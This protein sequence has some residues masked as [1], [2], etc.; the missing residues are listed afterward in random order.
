MTTLNVHAHSQAIQDVFYLING[1]FF[2]E[3]RRDIAVVLDR[4]DTLDFIKTVDSSLYDTVQIGTEGDY[5]YV[6]SSVV[7][8]EL[9]IENVRTEDGRI[10]DHEGDILILPHYVPQEV[11]KACID[12]SAVVIELALESIY[13]KLVKIIE[14]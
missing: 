5:F 13:E 9:F 2:G 12:G 7:A 1:H 6:T 3:D 11:K 10:K 8:S 14:E 4:E